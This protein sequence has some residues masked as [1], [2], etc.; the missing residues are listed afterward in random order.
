MTGVV[1]RAVADTV[2]SYKQTLHAAETA[3]AE[4]LSFC[5]LYE[6]DH[7]RTRITYTRR[8]LQPTLRNAALV[9]RPWQNAVRKHLYGEIHISSPKALNLLHRTLSECDEV[10]PLVRKFYFSG[11]IFASGNI[12]E[13]RVRDELRLREREVIR[14]CPNLSLALQDE[15]ASERS[16]R[17]SEKLI[18]DVLTMFRMDCLTHVEILAKCSLPPDAFPRS[19]PSLQSLKIPH[20][21]ELYS[22]GFV[23][24]S[25]P[26]LRRLGLTS[27]SP[28][29]NKGLVLPIF[30]PGIRILEVEAWAHEISEEGF[31]RRLSVWG[32]SLESVTVWGPGAG[33]GTIKFPA[34]RKTSLRE[35]I[36]KSV[37]RKCSLEYLENLVQLSI[38][39]STFTEMGRIT[40]TPFLENLFLYGHNG[41]KYAVNIRDLFYG[42][43]ELHRI[44]TLKKE[45]KAFK[46]LRRIDFFIF[47]GHPNQGLWRFLSRVDF[48]FIL[49][50]ARKDTGERFFPIAIKRLRVT[51]SGPP[52]S[53]RSP[54]ILGEALTSTVN[55]AFSS[56]F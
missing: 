33:F 23:F 38:P 53:S 6:R 48:G 56:Y 47:N 44:A 30:A 14:L 9:C 42:L 35:G 1:A 32:K 22:K 4:V 39:L 34:S 40:F 19:F 28:S 51:F 5:I 8:T 11:A 46:R 27:V 3:R 15:S 49:T 29:R 12:L 43:I 55:Y 21:S 41:D 2:L 52:Y 36:R 13:D 26:R 24:A 18:D 20:D 10:R 7:S 37:E 17:E 45:G 54:G 50:I 16:F 25:M 31:L